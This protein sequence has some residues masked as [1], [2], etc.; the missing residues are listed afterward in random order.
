MYGL[1]NFWIQVVDEIDE[2]ITTGLSVSISAPNI[3]ADE[4]QTAMTNPVTGTIANGV[5]SFWTAASSVD[6]IVST[7]DGGISVKRNLTVQAADHRIVLPAHQNVLEKAMPPVEFFDDFLSMADIAAAGSG[8][9]WALAADSGG[10]ATIDDARDGVLSLLTGGTNEDGSTLSS[11]DEIFLAD[12][13][14]N[15]FFEARVKLTETATDDANIYVGLCDIV[16]VDTMQDAGAGPAATLDG[17]G[18]YKLDGN[19]YW[20][21]E[22]SNAGT[23]M[24]NSDMVAYKS[25]TWYRL[26]FKYDYNDGVTAK[27]TPYVDGKAYPQV[28]LTISGMAEMNVVLSVKT[29]DTQTETLKVDYVRV[30]ADRDD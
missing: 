10:T 28:N 8:E 5:V 21:F 16:T 14:K 30:V 1:R 20:E 24:A 7:A 19:L 15:F 25:A 17:I 27:V 3:Y 22:T 4:Y 2:P 9:R 29:G 23:P 18:F 12:T 6:V 26:G 13:D 11:L